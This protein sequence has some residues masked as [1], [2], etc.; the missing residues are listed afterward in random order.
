[1][2]HFESLLSGL[3]D[4]EL[5]EA[6]FNELQA[7]LAESEEYRKA[8]W[9]YIE[10]HSAMEVV[11]ERNAS[12]KITQFIS[13]GEQLL[14]QQARKAKIIAACGAVAVALITAVTLKFILVEIDPNLASYAISPDTRFHITNTTEGKENF[15]QTGDIVDLR[16]GS[17]ELKFTKGVR[18][19]VTG[20]AKF[21]LA[22]ESLLNMEEGVA[23]FHVPQ[24]AVGFTVE[25][26]QLKVVDLGT[27]F[28]VKQVR[29]SSPEVHVFTGRVQV[30]SVANTANRMELA[31]GS[32]II[33]SDKGNLETT[34]NNPAAFQTTLPD[35][36]PYLYWSFDGDDGFQAKGTHSALTELKST[37]V[38]GAKTTEK[39]YLSL[40]GRNQYLLTNWSGFSGPQPRSIAFDLNLK[41]VPAVRG[42]PGIVAWGSDRYIMG[43]WKVAIQ[44]AEMPDEYRIRISF[45]SYRLI[46]YKTLKIRKWHQVVV[47][48][49]GID[50]ESQLPKVRLYI[51]AEEW[52]LRADTSKKFVDF[53]VDT[54]T[55]SPS[56]RPLRIGTTI[57][58]VDQSSNYIHGMIDN[59]FIFDGYLPP[60]K[61][62]HQLEEIKQQTKE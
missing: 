41:S 50:P 31:A 8:Y 14:K 51:D 21:T 6:E 59:L 30:T 22:D 56:S 13:R 54:V 55:D 40:N 61:L 24:E 18:A 3:V 23:W 32:A 52:D 39:G 46:T 29:D 49:D 42:N 60:A 4:Q 20:P 36:L 16:Q 35:Y 19:I 44:P 38:N 12:Q 15:I 58:P 48:F 43:R 1:M 27:E 7:M 34:T 11:I 9:K 53:D 45:G 33:L 47:A 25:T 5:T 10:M 57:R 28:A 62:I 17:M 2:E 26:P 37:P